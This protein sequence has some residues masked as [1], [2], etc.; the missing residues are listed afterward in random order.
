MSPMLGI[1][2]SQ[3][4]VRTK[5]VDILLIAGGG[6]GGSYRGGGGGA[7]GTIA[8][9]AQGLQIGSVFTI[10]VGAGGAGGSS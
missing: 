7:G 8:Y 2:A 6:G 3:N 5:A 4:Y 10:G 1:M 9:A